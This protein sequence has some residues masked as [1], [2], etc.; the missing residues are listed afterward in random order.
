MSLLPPA[1]LASQAP[2]EASYHV[3]YD[4]REDSGN[5]ALSASLARGMPQSRRGW[6]AVHSGHALPWQMGQNLGLRPGPYFSYEARHCRG[7]ES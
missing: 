1:A 5:C 2:S 3:I 6:E 7:R 4:C